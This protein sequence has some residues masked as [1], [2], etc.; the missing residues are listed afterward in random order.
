MCG[1]KSERPDFLVKSSSF[2]SWSKKYFRN[3]QK[4]FAP[5]FKHTSVKT[6]ANLL[7]IIGNNV[8]PVWVLGCVILRRSS[9]VLIDRSVAICTFFSFFS[10]IFEKSR[11]HLIEVL[12]YSLKYQPL[13]R[14]IKSNFSL[15]TAFIE[16][17][18][19]PEVT[20]NRPKI[21]SEL[22]KFVRY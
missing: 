2:L 22:K 6:L 19:C 17:P 9:V 1:N 5:K 8:Y 11:S 10:F 4:I 20:P 3:V 18:K 16:C 14:R 12:T 15:I 13:Y 7:E 21:R